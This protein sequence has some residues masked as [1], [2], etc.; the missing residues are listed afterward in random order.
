MPPKPAGGAKRVPAKALRLKEASAKKAAV[1]SLAKAA[2]GKRAPQG[3]G[4]APAGVPGS[5]SAVTDP[6]PEDQAAEIMILRGEY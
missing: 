6:D 4:N 1:K 3:S 5:A 2:S